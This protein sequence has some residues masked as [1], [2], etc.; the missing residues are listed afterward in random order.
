MFNGSFG[1]RSNSSRKSIRSRLSGRSFLNV[2]VNKD[3]TLARGDNLDLLKLNPNNKNSE[4]LSPSRKRVN[5]A[6]KRQME[7]KLRAYY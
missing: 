2:N 4:S 6:K 1:H 3:D 5:S 7:I